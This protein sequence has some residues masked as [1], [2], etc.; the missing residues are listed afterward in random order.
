MKL[1]FNYEE[2]A[3]AL[4]IGNDFLKRNI[5]RLPHRGFGNRVLFSWE[6]LLA[7]NDMY[8]VAPGQKA[9]TEDTP[10]PLPKPAA[11]SVAALKPRGASRKKSA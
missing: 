2:A 5:T 11:K 4:G 3:L 6:D 1:N 10:A 7:I 9:A 8:F